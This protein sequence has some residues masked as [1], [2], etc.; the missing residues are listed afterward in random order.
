VTDPSGMLVALREK[1]Y[2]DSTFN[3]S[4]GGNVFAGDDIDPTPY[5]GSSNAVAIVRSLNENEVATPGSSLHGR[6]EQ[7]IQFD[8]SIVG[9][10]FWDCRQI[11]QQAIDLIIGDFTI[12]H[13]G[14]SYW[15]VIPNVTRHHIKDEA[16]YHREIITFRGK[17]WRWN[18]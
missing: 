13:E 8:I 18:K 2:G 1:L 15:M 3:S 14:I 4:V 12:T 7:D 5:L 17:T 9:S 11:A 6:I 10:D 16:G